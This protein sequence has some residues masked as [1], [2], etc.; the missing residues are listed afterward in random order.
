VFDLASK[1]KT[2]LLTDWQA[3]KGLAWNPKT[4][5]IW[6]GGSRENKTA[7]INS[8]SLSGQVQEKVYWLPTQNSR[9]EDISD[10]GRILIN[11]GISNH[12]TVTMLSGKSRPKD[13]QTGG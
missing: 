5:D 11:R 7:R 2:D 10:D 13:I 12:T 9:V 3:L 6:F 8:V 4:N 1:Q